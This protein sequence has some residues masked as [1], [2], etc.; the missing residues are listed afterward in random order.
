MTGAAA[1]REPA[2]RILTRD[3]GAAIAYHACA[4]RQPGVVFLGGLNS[5]MTGTKATALDAAC[6]TA[7]REFLRFDYFGHGASS[8]SFTDGTIGRW[9]DDAIAVLDHLT[10]GP[11]VLVGS[12]MGG[13]IMLLAA[14]RRPQRVAGLI[15][16]AAAPDFTEALMWARYDDSVRRTL[17][18]EGLYLEPSDYSAEPYPITYRLIE[19]GRRHLVLDAP[20][21]ISCPVRLIHGMRDGDVPWRHALRL[22]E[23]L[24]GTDVR[25]ALVKDGDHR[26]AEP[27]HLAEICATVLALCEALEGA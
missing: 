1:A 10:E 25:L 6:R 23:A 2:P 3:G 11:Q 19:E 17:E 8:G 16:I 27:P 7:G 18:T 26:L 13:W 21:A 14:L 20:V 5:D 9:A 22:V 12:S 4:G 15:G 24:R